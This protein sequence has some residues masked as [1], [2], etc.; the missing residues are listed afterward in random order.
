MSRRTLS[1]QEKAACTGMPLQLF[2]PI[3]DQSRTSLQV[4]E[5]KHVCD[6]CEVVSDCLTTA[7]DAAEADGIWGGHTPPERRAMRRRRA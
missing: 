4:A 6:R 3:G 7:L 2:F 5:A 1:W